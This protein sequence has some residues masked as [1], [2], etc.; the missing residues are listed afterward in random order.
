MSDRET[1]IDVERDVNVHLE[2]KSISRAV[3]WF[4]WALYA[5]VSMTKNCYNSSLARIVSDGVLTKSQTGLITAMFY[6]VYTPLQIVGGLFSDRFSPER[7]IKIGLIGAALSNA[8]IFFCQNYYVMLG[9]WVFN[10][11][12][13]F[14]IWPSVFKI[15]SSQ[16]VRSDRSRMIFYLS[17]T[18]NAGFLVSYIIGAVVPDWRYNFA[19]SAISLLVFAFALHFIEKRIN[20]YMVWDKKETDE[21]SGVKSGEHSKLKVFAASGFFFVCFS[22][23]LAVTV[24]QARSTLTSV[25]FVENYE[26]V[27]PSLG[28]V[29]T[30]VLL[31]SGMLGTIISR[32]FVANS[33]NE[34][35]SMVF[36]IGAMLPLFAVCTLVGVLPIPVMVVMLALIACLESVSALLRSYYTAYFTKFGLNGSAAGIINAG[37]AFSY[38]LAAYVMPRFVETFGWH[39]FMVLLPVLLGV[40]ILSLCIVVKHFGK[41]KRTCL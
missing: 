37:T 39:T 28:N 31:V 29:L 14:G 27:S 24:S 16:L 21:L 32:K 34:L 35:L 40:S 15:V 23:M 13:Q 8:A 3:F 5:I 33:K 6:L 38:M 30:A 25:M 26:S 2:N 22:V 10:G 17:F 4:I 18:S 9:A 36:V 19:I 11:M 1:I 7:M 12:I 41:F 20:P